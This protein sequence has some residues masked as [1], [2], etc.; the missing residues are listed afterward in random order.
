MSCS[1]CH[2]AHETGSNNILL[3]RDN[4]VTPALGTKPVVFTAN[5]TAANY[6][7]GTTPFNGVCE[8]CHTTAV[9]HYQAASGGTSDARHFPAPQKCVNCH[10][11]NKGFAAQTDCFACHNVITDKP[12]IG[13]PGGRRQIVDNLGNGT[14]TGGDFKRTSHHALGAIPTVDD[15]LKCHYMGD[16]KKGTVKLLDPDQGYMSIITYDAA[17]KAGVEDFCLNCHDANGAAGDLTPFSDNTAVPL[18]D[19]A[20]WTASA[21]KTKPYTCMDCHDNGHGSNK[22]NMLGPWNYAGAGTGTDL[23]NE[24]EGFCLTCHGAG[25]TAT[26][27]VH[28]SFANNAN[29]ST[30]FRKHDPTASYRKHIDGENTGSA[31]GG[32]NRHVECVDC[33]NPHSAKAYV[34]TTAPTMYNGLIGASGVTPSYAGAGAPTGFTFN[35]N[36]TYEYEVCYKCHSSFTTLPT[37]LPTGWSGTAD[38]ADGLKKLTT[39]GTNTQV[40]DSRDMAQEY[41]PANTSYH[42]VMAAGKNLNINAATFQTGWTFTSRVY[43]SSCHDNNQKATAGYGRGPHGSQNLHILDAGTGTIGTS[44]NKTTHNGANTATTDFCSK[45]HQAAS[46]ISGNTSSRFGYHLY[47]VANKTKEGC[48]LCHDTHG[49][50]T[51]HLMNFSRNQAGGCIT[52]VGTNTQAAFVHA[53]GTASNSCTVTCHGTSHGSGKSYT[54]AY[55]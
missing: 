41:N 25:G 51:F 42:P 27:Q 8:V 26:V 12:G 55:N 31:F 17:N 18:V 30:A 44:G 16:H 4:I 3:V 34:A 50:E 2:Y 14:G 38:E 15:C 10:P 6:A 48:Y 40:A 33:H 9:D 11:H 23:T 49:S 19:K 1:T 52:S 5:S 46:Y 21:H 22:K 35:K 36:T 7:D 54:P 47:H 20:R 45:C 39:G 43:C 37:Y 24:E 28:L 53:A 29:T 32:A 13:P